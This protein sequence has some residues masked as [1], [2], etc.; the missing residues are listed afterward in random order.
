M[1]KISFPILM[2]LPIEI[3]L[4]IDYSG[5]LVT[6]PVVDASPIFFKRDD[7]YVVNPTL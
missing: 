7:E 2:L 1:D 4:G 5:M 3:F 6:I